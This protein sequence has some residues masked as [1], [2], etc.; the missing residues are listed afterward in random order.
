MPYIGQ[1]PAP[2]VVTSSDLAD[3][4]VTADKIGDTAISGFNALGATPADTDELLVSDAGTLKRV[5]FSHLK[6]DPTHV[7][8]ST[9]TI[10]SGTASVVFNS[11][12][13]TSTYKKYMVDA[14][15]LILG[16]QGNILMEISNDN[17]S[18]YE[19]ASAYAYAN[20][21]YESAG[22]EERTSNGGHNGG[23]LLLSADTTSATKRPCNFRMMIHD[24]LSTSV[25]FSYN[26]TGGGHDPNDKALAFVGSGLYDQSEGSAFNNIR[27]KPQSGNF[28]AGILKFYGVT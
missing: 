8:L 23:F 13:I 14:T 24:P 18:S 26:L 1:Q 3:D 4:V 7:L 2:K 11:S 5:D 15:N 25:Y 16:T 6:S 12:L 28:N 10:S 17:G 9:S 22:N 19:S 21:G 20:F 27:F